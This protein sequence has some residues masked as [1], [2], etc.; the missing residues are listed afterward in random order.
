[1]G[2]RFGLRYDCLRIL[3]NLTL[4]LYIYLPPVGSRSLIVDQRTTSL[5]NSAQTKPEWAATRF[6]EY[7]LKDQ[8][9]TGR[10]WALSSQQPPTDDREDRRRADLR[11][12]RWTSKGWQTIAFFEAKKQ[13]CTQPEVHELLF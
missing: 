4:G 9:F 6:W 1:M 8:F 5:W 7:V 12:E 3:D 10:D 11:I 2:A 13:N